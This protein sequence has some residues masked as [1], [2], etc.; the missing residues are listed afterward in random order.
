MSKVL[1]LR[2]DNTECKILRVIEY[3]SVRSD[4]SNLLQDRIISMEKAVSVR[5][6]EQQ[7]EIEKSLNVD[8]DYHVKHGC[9]G[10]MEV[11]YWQSK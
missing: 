6:K 11:Y 5:M 3:S 2:I 9:G 1:E 7:E 10:H 4:S 8:L